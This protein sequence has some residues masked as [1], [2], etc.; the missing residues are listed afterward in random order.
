M[1]DLPNGA[2]NE[3]GETALEGGFRRVTREPEPLAL[4]RLRELVL[5]VAA[6]GSDQL[7]AGLEGFQSWRSLATLCGSEWSAGA[8]RSS[9]AARRILERRLRELGRAP[10]RLE[11]AAGLPIGASVHVR[12]IVRHLRPL[13][14]VDPASSEGGLKSHIWSRSAMNTDNV[15]VQVEEGHDFFLT[16]EQ[17]GQTAC[18]MVARGHL[19][20][21]EALAAG[22]RVSVFGCV[23]RSARAT[24]RIDPFDR[25]PTGLAIR[26]GD[27]RPLLVRKLAREAQ[28]GVDRTFE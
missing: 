3:L 14:P 28:A 1:D 17:S 8:R 5:E 25:A 18:V 4:A 23:D 24:A 19:V 10:C 11:H 9:A 15:R 22:D 13:R 6:G 20:N 12:G 2:S 21:A 26:A 16:D 7:R 27:D